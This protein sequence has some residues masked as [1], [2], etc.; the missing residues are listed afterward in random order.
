[1]PPTGRITKSR[2]VATGLARLLGHSQGTRGAQQEMTVNHPWA[3]STSLRPVCCECS[4]S[5]NRGEIEREERAGSG[6]L[7]SRACSS[8]SLTPATTACSARKTAA[9]PSS[10][11]PTAD[12]PQ[13]VGA[14]DAARPEGSAEGW[15]KS[16]CPSRSR[17]PAAALLGATRGSRRATRCNRQ[18]AERH[19]ADV[20]HRADCIGGCDASCGEP[21][22]TQRR[23]GTDALRQCPKPRLMLREVRSTRPQRLDFLCLG[24]ISAAPLAPEPTT[25]PHQSRCLAGGKSGT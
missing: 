13:P 22:A 1:M 16:A 14:L 5:A 3:T 18:R 10:G 24:T 23:P 25:G 20:E 19:L 11:P 17:E 8:R 7:P 4:R 12:G 9:R 21:A 2:P 6:W 15:Q